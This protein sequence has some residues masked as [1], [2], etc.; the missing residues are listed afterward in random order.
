MR[1]SVR[2]LAV[3]AFLSLIPFSSSIGIIAPVE[4]PYETGM[5]ESAAFPKFRS[6]S[7][8]QQARAIPN[9][10]ELHEDEWE[11]FQKEAFP[12]IGPPR[13]TERH[14]YS[15]DRQTLAPTAL[16][17]PVLRSSF[18]G[19]PNVSA[20]QP[21][22]IISVG[23][24]HVMVAVNTEVAIYTKTGQKVFQTSFAEWFKSLDIQTNN[25]FDPKMLYDQYTGHF[26]FLC[27][28]RRADKRSFFL[29]SVSK[30]QDPTGAWA[31]WALDMGLNG[32][33][34]QDV[35]WADFPRLGIDENAIYLTGNMTTFG[36]FLFKYAKLRILKKS[37]VYSFGKLTW[38]DFWKMKDGTGFNAYSMEPA[39]S[40][41]PAPMEFLVNTSPFTG[42]VL[43]LWTLKGATTAT[44]VLTKKAITVSSYQYPPPAEQ[45]GGG[46]KLATRECGVYN[47]VSRNGFIHT[48]H[49]VSN[50]WGSGPVSAIRYYQVSTPGQLVQEITYGADR[51]HYYYPVVMPDSRNNVYMGFNRSSTATF[52]GAFFTGRKAGGP[53]GKFQTSSRLAPGLANFK[54][55]FGG[56]DIG[57]WGD[58][59]GISIDTDDTVYFY[60]Q[61]AQ[62]P[63]AWNT[64]VGLL[65]YP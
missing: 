5:G 4:A 1:L 9:E 25:L 2:V 34:R 20:A 55:V 37:Q 15:A 45:K 51:M 6:L 18:A 50:D 44:P 17:A 62:A 54:V 41:G 35:L 61:Y 38:R 31:F 42:R 22:C 64:R 56:S 63:F 29:F 47:A 46:P 12:L 36:S 27:N 26:I 32:T 8:I 49:N 13:F 65:A 39:H 28:A 58:Y 14:S 40:Y 7:E 16:N 30:T 43:T 24:D 10:E 33:Q 57:R 11:Y 23:P 19:I 48:A 59:A 52:A 53:A 21:D 3:L 60:G